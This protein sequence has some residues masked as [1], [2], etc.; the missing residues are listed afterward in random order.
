MNLTKLVTDRILNGNPDDDEGSAGGH[1][2]F[3][4]DFIT[5]PPE[6]FYSGQSHSAPHHPLLA[7]ERYF[8]GVFGRSRQGG[9][10]TLNPQVTNNEL[11]LQ[12][13]LAHQL[14]NTKRLMNTPRF[15]KT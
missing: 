13:R 4:R 10:S 9:S 2:G 12:N 14:G 8:S 15:T 1:Q 3:A 6:D 5:L 7:K 11:A